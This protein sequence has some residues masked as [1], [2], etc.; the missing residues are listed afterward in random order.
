[1]AA[2]CSGDL[3][4]RAKRQGK[5]AIQAGIVELHGIAVGDCDVAD[6]EMD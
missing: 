6:L 1:M 4:E 5:R 2:V 3:C